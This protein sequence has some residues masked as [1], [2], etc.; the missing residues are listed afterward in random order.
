MSLPELSDFR[1][2][3]GTALSLL[4]GHRESVDIDMFCDGPY[5][6]IPFDFILE[7]LRLKF[8][9][10]E[11][12][13]P[14]IGPSN[15][16][17]NQGLYLFIGQNEETSIKCDILYWDAPFLYPPIIE[18][19][20]RLATIEDIATMKLDTI[21]R[22]GRKKDFWDLSDILESYRFSDLIEIYKE[23]Y[24][25]FAVQDVIKGLSDFTIADLMPDPICFKHKNWEMI[26]VEMQRI[27]TEYNIAQ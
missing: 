8:S 25:W 21:S 26:K 15:L 14:F 20:I 23:K 11:E 13:N 2:V 24:P 16:A 19:G 22:G 10:V 9:Y 4:R 1:L 12:T 17:N 7:V 18:D 5:G 27:A 6:E 3:G